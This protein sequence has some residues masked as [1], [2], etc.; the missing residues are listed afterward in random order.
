MSVNMKFNSLVVTIVWPIQGL[1]VHYKTH[2]PD[3][4]ENVPI[5]I[6]YLLLIIYLL[7]RW[8]SKQ[9]YVVHFEKVTS[10]WFV[11]VF[12]REIHCIRETFPDNYSHLTAC[13]E[14]CLNTKLL[15]FAF[16]RVNSDLDL[17]YRQGQ[18]FAGLN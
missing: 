4:N 3:K 6:Y 15:D 1:E 11:N 14:S 7:L 17:L 18:F 12:A 8:L 13:K 16:C 9:H 5:V 10:N 2:Y